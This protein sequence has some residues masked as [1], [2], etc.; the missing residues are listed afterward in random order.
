MKPR[1]YETK[2]RNGTKTPQKVTTKVPPE[3]WVLRFP[4]IRGRP[5]IGQK[6]GQ[7]RKLEQ[8]KTSCFDLQP[9]IA[10]KVLWSK[11][12]KPNI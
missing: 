11:G 8:R 10:R 7:K 3:P 12:S 4:N 5:D 2:I 1:T 9:R 6:Q